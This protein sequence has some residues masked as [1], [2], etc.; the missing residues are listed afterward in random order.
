M[1]GILIPP[2][3]ANV[4]LP[5][6]VVCELSDTGG[7]GR[8]SYF[9]RDG[10]RMCGPLSLNSPT[11]AWSAWLRAFSVF[12]LAQFLAKLFPG[13]CDI[14][15]AFASGRI[16]FLARQVTTR[17][18]MFSAAL[19]RQVRIGHGGILSPHFLLSSVK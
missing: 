1:D 13:S 2:N 12:E 19:W 5:G 6:P 8:T 17:G 10:L 11:S 9:R 16:G 7:R 4:K 15:Q 18:G 3:E 14:F